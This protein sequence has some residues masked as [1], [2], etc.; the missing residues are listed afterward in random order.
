VNCGQECFPSFYDACAVFFPKEPFSIA[1]SIILFP[2][3]IDVVQM[4][5][6]FRAGMKL[7]AC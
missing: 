7:L 1:A 5:I 3:I 2:L 6:R 4:M